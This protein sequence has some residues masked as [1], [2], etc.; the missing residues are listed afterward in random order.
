MRI[1]IGAYVWG[2][3][4]MGE[5]YQPAWSGVLGLVQAVEY[6]ASS[7]YPYLKL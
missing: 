3:E 1:S 2:G 7:Y 5:V 4:M 6:I